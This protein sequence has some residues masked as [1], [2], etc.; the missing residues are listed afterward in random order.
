MTEVMKKIGFIGV[1]DK[2]DLIIYVSRVLVEMGKRVLIIDSTVNQK[3]K[4]VVPTINPTTSYVTEYEGIDVSVGFRDYNSIKRYLGFPE[5]AVLDYDYIFI[6]IDD[7]TLLDSFDIYSSAKNYFVTSPDLFDLKKG[8]EILSG[9]RQ[10]L[11]L[12][13]I[14][15][16]NR[17]T[18]AEDE[19]LNFLSLGYKINW[20]DEKIYFPMLSGDR[21]IIIE[22][23][24]LSKIKFK[25]ISNEYKDSLIY[26]IQEISEEGSSNNIKKILKKLERG[27]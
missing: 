16:S 12:T 7:P 22:N 18:R 15:F 4:Y 17:M 20:N 14:L 11:E 19:Y 27:V 23:Q 6:D 13:K 8:L 3:A 25:G 5:S 10:P 9:V 24:R 26:L 21:D 1:F 2:T